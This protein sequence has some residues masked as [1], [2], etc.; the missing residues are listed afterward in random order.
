MGPETA[1]QATL[2]YS[3]Y[4]EAIHCN[5]IE[6]SMDASERSASFVLSG[7][8]FCIIG[9][10]GHYILASYAGTTPDLPSRCGEISGVRSVVPGAASSVLAACRFLVSSL[11]A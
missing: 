5:Q 9:A 7:P 6:T 2:K 4:I 8:E 10:P 3:E 1:Q 11:R